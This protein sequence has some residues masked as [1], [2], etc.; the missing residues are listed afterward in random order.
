[1]RRRGW[2]SRRRASIQG[3]RYKFRG[4]CNG[5]DLQYTTS[6][7][8]AVMIPCQWLMRR[9]RAN[10]RGRDIIQL[11]RSWRGRLCQ[12]ILNLC[13]SLC[14]RCNR[15]SPLQFAAKAAASRYADA[16]MPIK[17]LV[18]TSRGTGD[19]ASNDSVHFKQ[20]GSGENETH[21]GPRLGKIE[22]R[23]TCCYR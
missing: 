22:I 20:R 16:P 14:A 6:Y 8:G 2:T 21:R 19:K 12:S 23:W 11:T 5:S 17:K 7:P 9:W 18:L 3:S 15:C 10:R 1:M 4:K 13:I